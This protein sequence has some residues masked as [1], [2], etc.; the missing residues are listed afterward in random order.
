MDAV[1]PDPTHPLEEYRYRQFITCK[2]TNELLKFGFAIRYQHLVVCRLSVMLLPIRLH[3]DQRHV[4]FCVEFFSSHGEVELVHP[5][6]AGAGA[7]PGPNGSDMLEEALLPFFQVILEIKEFHTQ[8]FCFSVP[9]S[10]DDSH[11]Q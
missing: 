5:N 6:N 9:V 4:D 3:L 10:M 1:R 11:L 2:G 8:F 7:R